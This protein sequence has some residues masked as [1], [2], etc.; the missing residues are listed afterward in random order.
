M[1][2]LFC[3]VSS[4]SWKISQLS[5]ALGKPQL[6]RLTDDSLKRY[7]KIYQCFKLGLSSKYKKKEFSALSLGDPKYRFAKD[8]QEYPLKNAL[9]RTPNSVAGRKS[10]YQIQEAELWNSDRSGK[11]LSTEIYVGARSTALS[12]HQDL[13]PEPHTRTSE[14]I[15]KDC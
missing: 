4:V 2:C 7:I 6:C 3:L 11:T 12:T 5:L 9:A 8:I 13:I 15:S 1:L 10:M 14:R